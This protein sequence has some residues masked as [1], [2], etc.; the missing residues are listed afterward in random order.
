MTARILV[1]AAALLA[2]P[3]NAQAPDTGRLVPTRLRCEYAVGPLGIDS[4]APRLFWQVESPDRGERQTA[5]QIGSGE[6]SGMP[7]MR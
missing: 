4:A 5:W 6:E 7:R 3:L 1:L 2:V